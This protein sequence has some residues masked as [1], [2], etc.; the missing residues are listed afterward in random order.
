MAGTK[1]SPELK[2]LRRLRRLVDQDLH[3]AYLIEKALKA[4]NAPPEE[5]AKVQL[6]IK[7]GHEQILDLIKQ[8]LDCR[9]GMPEDGRLKLQ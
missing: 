1:W 8:D 5:I 3:E 2:R 7:A 6:R 4:A 9:F